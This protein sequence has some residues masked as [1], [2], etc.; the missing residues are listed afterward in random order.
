M[1]WHTTVFIAALA[2]ANG[3]AQHHMQ[4][5]ALLAG[6]GI[7]RHPISTANPEAQKFFDQGLTLLYGFNRYEALRSFRRAAELDPRAAMPWWGMAMAL[8]P[9]IN[10][11][12]EPP[13]MT[14]SCEAAASGLR[15]TSAPPIE[16]AYVEAVM[17]RCPDYDPRKYAAAMRMLGEH[18]PDDPDALTFYAES[19]LVPVRWRWY[20]SGGTPADGVVDAEHTLEQVLR[21][22]PNHPGANHFYIHAVES[23]PAPERGIAS[24]QRLMG[25]VPAAGH[26]V[27]MPGHIWMVLGD[28]ETAAQVNERAAELDRRYMETTGVVSSSY[29]GYYAHNLQFLLAARWMQGDAANALNASAVLAEAMAPVL[30][31]MPEMMDPFVEMPL[32]TRV[33]FGLWDAVLKSPA[34]DAKFLASAAVYHY[35]RA[36]ALIARGDRTAALREQLEFEAARAKVPA[37]RMWG[38]N[39][40]AD[41]LAMASKIVAAR[42]AESAGEGI[43]HGKRAVEMQDAFIYDE[44]APWYYPVRESLGAALLR[45]GNAAE[46]ETV[47]REGL[48]RSPRNG[49]IL[50]GLFESL[51][52]Q[53]KREAGEWVRREHEA[54][55]GKTGMQLRIEDF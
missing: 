22:F 29:A 42:V 32:I 19:L 54:A 15:R 2:A 31:A 53:G 35:A 55:W 52:A 23:S 21:R 51:K 38:N 36:V 24:A 41:V 12:F 7:W 45:A 10:M 50:F 26:L 33:R 47:F 30:D 27:H 48:R 11:D 39:K 28:Y 3:L 46:A 43:L 6:L 1:T 4:P 5:V 9:H 17:S 16:R 34:P 20:T 49:R 44:P 37:D 8:G 13:D 25:I 40:T 14:G 18:Y